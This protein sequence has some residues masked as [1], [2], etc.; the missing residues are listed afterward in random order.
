MLAVTEIQPTPPAALFELLMQAKQS[1]L[2]CVRSRHELNIIDAHECEF[3][4][5]GEELGA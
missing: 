5:A 3:A 1:A 4:V 2:P